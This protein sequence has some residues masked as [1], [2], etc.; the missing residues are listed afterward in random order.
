ME[1]IYLTNQGYEKLADELEF[2]KNVKRKEITEALEHA[3]SLGDLK[4]NAEYHAAKDAIS[5]N[6]RKIR[7][8][9]DK[10]SRVEILDDSKINKNKAYIGA[11]LTI[12]DLDT[13]EEIEYKLVSQDEANALEGLISVT[14]PVGQSLLG[15]KKNDIIEVEVPAGKLSYKILKI[16][17]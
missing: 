13:E 9:E 16:S 12:F 17:H 14:S 15:H 3:R 10:L 8:L 11:K 6:E 7:E 2:L 4:E 1:R 5:Q